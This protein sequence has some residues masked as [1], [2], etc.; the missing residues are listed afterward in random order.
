[1]KSY[2]TES[3]QVL[4]AFAHD[5]DDTP[6]VQECHAVFLHAMCG[7]VEDALAEGA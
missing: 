1:M 4:R 3:Y 2:L 5:T 6:H 7:A